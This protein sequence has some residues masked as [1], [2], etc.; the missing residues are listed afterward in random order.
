MR[1]AP[2]TTNEL[3]CIREAAQMVRHAEGTIKGQAVRLVS[4]L[5]SRSYNSIRER[6]RQEL[7]AIKARQF[8]PPVSEEVL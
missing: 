2:W 3:K 6:L 7:D 4:I 1:A 5:S 8:L